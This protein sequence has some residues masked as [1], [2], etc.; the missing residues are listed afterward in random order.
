VKT[1]LIVLLGVVFACFRSALTLRDIGGLIRD[2]SR[3]SSSRY[4]T[5]RSLPAGYFDRAYAALKDPYIYIVVSDTGSPASRLIRIF[6]AARYNHISLSFDS[7]LETLV[8]YNGGNGVSNPGL[9]AERLEFL[10][11]Q[12]GASLAVYRLRLEPE[13]K[14]RLIERIRTIDREGSSY[15]LPGLLTG[16]SRLPNIMFCSQFVYSVLDDAGLAYFEKNEGAV[17]PEDFIRERSPLEFV[18]GFV[19]PAPGTR[20][21]RNPGFAANLLFLFPQTLR[22]NV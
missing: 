19:F 16:K 8:S 14:A 5:R 15:N 6:T 1:G 4:L 9:N 10:N 3:H 2:L 21:V 11:C 20:A 18:G 7:A 17:R 12:A 22:I 13:R